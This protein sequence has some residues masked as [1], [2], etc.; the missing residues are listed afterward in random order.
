MT[1]SDRW[2]RQAGERMTA[3]SSAARKLSPARIP[4]PSMSV[5]SLAPSQAK[6]GV[7]AA[8]VRS[9]GSDSSGARW[10]EQYAGRSRTSEK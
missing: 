5:Q 10:A 4:H 8:V 2:V 6:S 9:A 1:A 3:P 7:L